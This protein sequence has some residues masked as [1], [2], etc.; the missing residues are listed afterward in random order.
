MKITRQQRSKVRD[1]GIKTKRGFTLL[2]YILGLFVAIVVVLSVFNAIFNDGRSGSLSVDELKEMSTQNK[3]KLYDEIPESIKESVKQVGISDRV[4]EYAAGELATM[5]LSPGSEDKWD[6]FQNS[7]NYTDN[8]GDLYLPN[9]FRGL[10]DSNVK[11]QGVYIPNINDNFK[12]R[13][14]VLVRAEVYEEDSDGFSGNGQK[15]VI[16]DYYKLKID[17]YRIVDLTMYN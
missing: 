2:W 13:Y 16:L 9:T 3:G 7:E 6:A 8:F 10:G 11:I 14:K 15:L 1:I 12:D 5:L 4:T 17:D